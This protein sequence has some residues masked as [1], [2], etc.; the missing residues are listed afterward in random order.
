MF[1]NKQN[2]KIFLIDLY[3]RKCV[4][5]FQNIEEIIEGIAIKMENDVLNSIFNEKYFDFDYDDIN[6]TG[7]D[8]KF[9]RLPFVEPHISYELRR[10]IF[11]DAYNRIIDIR[12]YKDAIKK[13]YEENI[14]KS[15]KNDW[16]SFQYGEKLFQRAYFSSRII[17]EYRFRCEP[18]PDIHKSGKYDKCY[19]RV[20]TFAECRENACV[21]Y[22]NFIRPKRRY[23]P[24]LYDDIRRGNQKSWK[25]Q[26]KKKKQWM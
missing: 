19:R 1:E 16:D 20:R 17:K 12:Q 13:R 21:E 23:I 14:E 8:I 18:V 11:I 2:D 15:D 26:S 5:E 22:K 9:C 4:R 6:M 10:Y 25:R 24:T 7:N 3:E